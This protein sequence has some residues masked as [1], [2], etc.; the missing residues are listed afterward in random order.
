MYWFTLDEVSETVRVL[1][2]FHG[3]QQHLDRMLARLAAEGEGREG[4]RA[5]GEG[6]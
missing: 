3:G 2:I 1:G 5:E 6:G 4:E